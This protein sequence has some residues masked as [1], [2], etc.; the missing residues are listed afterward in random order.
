VIFIRALSVAKE[1][2]AASNTNAA[3]LIISFRIV[4]LPIE[5]ALNQQT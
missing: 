4:R 2:I 5:I 3:P 1:A